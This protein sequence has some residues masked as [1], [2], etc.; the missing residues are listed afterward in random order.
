MSVTVKCCRTCKHSW[1]PPEMTK[2]YRR[3]CLACKIAEEHA[4]KATEQFLI[5]RMPASVVPPAATWMDNG[6]FSG[7]NCPCF[8]RKDES[9]E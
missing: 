5:M 8:E 6:D 3:W 9:D 4:V 2:H 1:Q 7:C